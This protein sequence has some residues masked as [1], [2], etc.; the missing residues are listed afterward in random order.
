LRHL[1]HLYVYC[2][3]MLK[4]IKYDTRLN[5]EQ[6][7]HFTWQRGVSV[8]E[9]RQH[10]YLYMLLWSSLLTDFNEQRSQILQ[11]SQVNKHQTRLQYQQ[12]DKGDLWA[13][14]EVIKEYVQASK[15][16]VSVIYI[17]CWLT[18]APSSDVWRTFLHSNQEPR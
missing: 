4:M 7:P 11:A 1:L 9:V 2:S 5:S 6:L 3:W 18:T 13:P 17:F 8:R 12:K 16:K 14:L 15:I 10:C